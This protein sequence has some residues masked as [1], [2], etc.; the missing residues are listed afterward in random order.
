MTFDTSRTTNR[1]VVTKTTTNNISQLRLDVYNG[2]DRTRHQSDR[3]PVMFHYDSG[4]I[5]EP[6]YLFSSKDLKNMAVVNTSLGTVMVWPDI[7]PAPNQNVS[8]LARRSLFLDGGKPGDDMLYNDF[9]LAVTQKA[10]IELTKHNRALLFDGAIS[11]VTPYKYNSE[12]FLGDKVTLLAQ[13]GFE[14]SMIVS[15][16]IRTEDAEG[17]RGYPGL[18]LA[19]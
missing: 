5:D 7:T 9:M 16:Y 4:H 8:G 14:E 10:R 11:A 2:L 12:Y 13:Y 1:G 19:I 3:E 15:E 17:D 6:E 18:I